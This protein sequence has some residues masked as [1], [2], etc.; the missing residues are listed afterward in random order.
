MGILWIVYTPTLRAAPPPPH[1][2]YI[3]VQV[4]APWHRAVGWDERRESQYPPNVATDEDAGFRVR[5]TQPTRSWALARSSS[6]SGARTSMALARRSA[7]LPPSPARMMWRAT[8]STTSGWTW[9]W[10]R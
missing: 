2:D 3:A 6:A 5:S 4:K 9:R 7:R 8:R 10:Q 1:K